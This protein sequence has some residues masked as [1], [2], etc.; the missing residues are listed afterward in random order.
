MSGKFLP[1]D[2]VEREQFGDFPVGWLSRPQTT[3]A[4]NLTV[5]EFTIPPGTGLSFHKHPTQEEVAYVLSGTL[6]QWIGKEKRMLN[7]G[8]S[9]FMPAGVA[10]A[11]FNLVRSPGKRACDAQSMCR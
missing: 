8:D 6:E 10:H 3:G 5:L 7:A 4:K 11:S 2:A 1:A 9:V